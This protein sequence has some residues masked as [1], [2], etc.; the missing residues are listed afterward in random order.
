MQGTHEF[1][2]MSDFRF[3]AL[4]AGVR[5]HINAAGVVYDAQELTRSGI[6][7]LRG[8]LE[9]L[10]PLSDEEFAKY[11]AIIDED[12]SRSGASQI[13]QARATEEAK[14]GFFASLLE[15]LGDL[16][17]FAGGGVLVLIF[18][19]ALPIT[20]LAA[21]LT[22]ITTCLANEAYVLLLVGAIAFPIGIIHGI[23]LWLGYF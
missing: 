19:V 18:Y 13:L 22:H 20:C 2:V 23:G 17:G 9:R 4:V 5:H 21:W 3:G 1:S 6:D 15:A 8:D 11:K 16:L 14:G 7:N 10:S 12:A